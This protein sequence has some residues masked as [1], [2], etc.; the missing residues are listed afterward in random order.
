LDLSHDTLFIPLPD[1]EPTTPPPPPHASL[2]SAIC[3]LRVKLFQIER[4]FFRN[5]V[6]ICNTIQNITIQ[7]KTKTKQK[8]NKNKTK[9]RQKQKKTKT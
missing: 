4:F 5:K 2:H 9:T 1:F 7:Y 3:R 6:K 8:Q